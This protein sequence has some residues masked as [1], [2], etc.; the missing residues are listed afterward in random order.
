MFENNLLYKMFVIRNTFHHNTNFKMKRSALQLDLTMVVHYK[1]LEKIKNVSKH[2]Y[3]QMFVCLR[4]LLGDQSYLCR[5]VAPQI[6]S[7]VQRLLVVQRMWS[8][9]DWI[10]S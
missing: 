2:G 5:C 8:S 3:V 1:Q 4:L 7:L 6:V 9:F 10:E